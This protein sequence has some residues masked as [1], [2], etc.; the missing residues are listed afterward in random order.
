MKK[1]AIPFP[2][3]RL[4][5]LTSLASLNKKTQSETPNKEEQKWTSGNAQSADTR[6]TRKT[7][8][9]HRESKLEHRSS[10]CQKNGHAQSAEHQKANS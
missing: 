7:E 1:H 10:N 5:K 2:F 4:G 3:F 8:T 9:Q 6:T